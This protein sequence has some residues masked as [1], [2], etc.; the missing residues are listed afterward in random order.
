MHNQKASGKNEEEKTTTSSGD[1]K[2]DTESTQQKEQKRKQAPGNTTSPSKAEG[3]VHVVAATTDGSSTVSS[4]WAPRHH[5]TDATT[6]GNASSM[7]SSSMPSSF[8][9]ATHNHR[10]KNDSQQTNNASKKNMKNAQQA[11]IHQPSLRER[12]GNSALSSTLGILK[13]FG[14]VTLSTTGTILSPSIEMTR[15][16]LLPQLFAALADYISNISPQR[17]K[18]WFRILSASVHHIIAVIVSTE[19]GSI[20][21]HKF[22]RAFGDVVDVASSDTSRQAIMDGMACFVKLGEALQ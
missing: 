4:S 15:Q 16:V 7:N 19:R 18:D 10:L 2:I 21:R 8:P 5:Y 17:L 22:A 14:D 6:S 11:K 12:V 13:L 20:F 1:V 3:S 9:A